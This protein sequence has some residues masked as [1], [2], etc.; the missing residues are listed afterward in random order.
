M[1]KPTSKEDRLERAQVTYALRMFGITRAKVAEL[2]GRGLYTITKRLTLFI[3]KQGVK[4]E[5][6]VS[7]LEEREYLKCYQKIISENSDK[8]DKYLAKLMKR[9]GLVG[10][11]W[12]ES[13]ADHNDTSTE[14]PKWI[15]Y[16]PEPIPDESMLNQAETNKK[17][18]EQ[19]N[20]DIGNNMDA[21]I[22]QVTDSYHS[23]VY[24]LSSLGVSQGKILSFLKNAECFSENAY[25]EYKVSKALPTYEGTVERFNY[26]IPMKK[27]EQEALL[28]IIINIMTSKKQGFVYV[29]YFRQFREDKTSL[30]PKLGDRKWLVIHKKQDRDFFD[31]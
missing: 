1:K 16:S 10:V 3:N 27:I 25:N 8:Y 21:H 5:E 28:K 29:E 30:R 11:I 7:Y 2:F 31:H 15:L 14:A 17:I 9:K 4:K 23:L 20:A 24:A 6:K 26:L 19:L 18:D 12:I 13:L 22:D